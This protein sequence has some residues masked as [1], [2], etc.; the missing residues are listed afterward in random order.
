M[1]EHLAKQRRAV[2]KLAARIIAAVA[3]DRYVGVGALV[4]AQHV[5]HEFALLMCGVSL[6]GVQ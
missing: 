5:A 1:G 4:A 6:Y 3:R 2:M